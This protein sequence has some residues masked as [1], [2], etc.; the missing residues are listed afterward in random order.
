[1]KLNSFL[2]GAS[3]L[4]L[5]QI[6]I[7]FCTFF[8]NIIVARMITV[9]DYGIATTFAMTLALIEMTSNLAFDRILI[10]DKDGHSDR[11]L[12]SAHFLQFLKSLVTGAIL[13]LTAPLVAALFNLEDIL[14]A[15][16]LLAF[17]PII[18]GLVHFDAVT[19]QR[20]MRFFPTATIDAIPQV[21]TLVV[22]YP[23]AVW[24]E[25]YRV[26]LTLVIL[27]PFVSVLLSHGLAKRPY[28][29]IFDKALL[30]KKISF[31][32]PL[33]VNGLLLFAIFNGDKTIIGTLHGMEVLGWYGA[34]FALTMMPTLL[35]TKVCNTLLLPSLS[36][37]RE[38]PEIY[39]RYCMNSSVFCFGIALFS[40]AFFTFAGA[41]IIFLSYGIKYFAG[42]EVIAWLALMQ[43]L[44]II[45]IAPTTI[46]ISQADTKNPMIA[47]IVRTVALP[48]A[49]GFAYLDYPIVWLVYCAIGGEV[50]ATLTCVG[51]LKLG[52][53][54]KAYLKNFTL[55]SA[56]FVTLVL[57]GLWAAP[58]PDSQQT[59][60][61]AIL[62]TGFSLFI[63]VAT[64][65]VFFLLNPDARK[66]LLK[67]LTKGSSH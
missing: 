64:T 60:Y 32:W 39:L 27:Q 47:N 20:E 40:W 31:G 44:R 5:S 4:S 41:E 10:Q 6:T 29:W 42:T 17:I 38:N 53:E 28:R 24:L 48:I 3:I 54:K 34:V 16:Q 15:F 66:F 25:D 51:R 59:H 23:L 30:Y 11:L 22:A 7:A 12:A 43:S 13:L 49:I 1:M 55:V 8:R 45:R 37:N 33:M 46:A 58:T 62:N 21:V 26:M 19:Y 9:E 67:T 14:W 52:T 36:Q 18:K 56:L 57:L 50:L 61:Q 35:F 65:I 2:K 63:A